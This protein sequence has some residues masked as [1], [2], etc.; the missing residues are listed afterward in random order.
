M[1]I[2]FFNHYAVPPWFYPLYRPYKFATNLIEKG[3]SVTIFAASTVHNSN[4]NLIKDNVQYKIEKIDG[5]N[6]VYIKTSDYDGNGIDRIINMIQYS[7]K[8]LLVSKKINKPNVIMATSVHPLTWLVGYILSKKYDAK[9]I[10]ET[11]DLWPETL[12]AM[13]QI[14]KN[15]IPAKLLYKLEKFIYKKADRLIFTFPGGKD[16]V[17]EIGLDPS[18]VRYINNGVDLEEFNY[19]KE[20]YQY[21]DEDLDDNS[22]FKILYTGSMGQA[23]ELSYLLEAAKIIQDKGVK[24]IKFIL[25]GDGYQRKGLEQF[26]KDNNLQNVI[27]KGKVEKKYIPSI[28]SRSDLNVFTGK[29]IYLYKYGLSL[30]KMFDYFASGKPILS[31]IECGYDL[32][33]KY[34]CGET[35]KGGSSESLAEGIL[36]FYNMP[37]EEYNIYCKNALKAAQ[38]FDFKILTDKLEKIILELESEEKEEIYAN[39]IN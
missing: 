15:S 5:I 11:A 32:L 33:E 23:N 26:A 17:E 19:N 8:L 21:A 10:A 12:V 25:F 24:N 16:Y 6:Y 29:H 22:T 37:K 27:F 30:N 38:D 2:W 35:V 7:F 18:K 4:E 9:F 3:H 36:R 20:K 13:G 39:T 1:D 28:L 14:K 34:N 31:N